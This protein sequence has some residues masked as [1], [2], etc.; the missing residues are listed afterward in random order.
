MPFT[1]PD[2]FYLKLT[3]NLAFGEKADGSE[4]LPEADEKEMAIFRQARRHLPPS[5]F[6]EAAGGR[7]WAT[8]GSSAAPSTC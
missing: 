4:A 7:P 1:H 6:D 5:V 2:H 3:A 8:R